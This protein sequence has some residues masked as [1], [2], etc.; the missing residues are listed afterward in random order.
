MDGTLVDSELNTGL[1]V[2]RLLTEEVDSINIAGLD[3][4]LCYGKTWASCLQE[5]LSLY[6]DL[7]TALG[8]DLEGEVRAMQ[9]LQD[10]FHNGATPPPINKAVWAVRQAHQSIGKT[11]IATSSDRQSLEHTIDLL[12]IRSNLEAA[13]S[14]ED[15]EK[16][17]PDPDPFLT[18]AKRLEVEDASACLVFE[19]SI[20]GIQAAK[21]AGMK[22]IAIL[23]RSPNEILAR[24]LADAAITSYAD[25]EEDFFEKIA[26]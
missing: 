22:V 19:D 17:K 4:T 13:L 1:A 26:A 5:M 24:S 20:A 9:K 7:K 2:E 6:P 25:L 11:A 16:S 21:N 12:D 3:E 15:Y 14:A 18:V 23:Q 8:E 10:Y